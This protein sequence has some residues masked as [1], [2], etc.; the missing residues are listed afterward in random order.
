MVYLVYIIVFL[1]LLHFIYE[2]IIAPSLRLKLRFE[3]FRLRDGLRLL[4]VDRPEDVSDQAFRAL[5]EVIN[6]S[7]RIL[8]RADIATVWQAH[9]KIADDPKLARLRDNRVR[10]LRDELNDTTR[11]IYAQQTKLFALALLVNNGMLVLYLSP[12]A[13]VAVFCILLGSVTGSVI[14]KL[15]DIVYIPENQIE[16]VVPADHFAAVA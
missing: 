12:L 16:N 6:N 1:A 10:V 5:Q 7:L 3:L 11:Q 9:R 2:G 13:L 15:M 14:R 8:H 4:K